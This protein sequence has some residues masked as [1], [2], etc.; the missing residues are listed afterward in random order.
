MILEAKNVL[1]YVNYTQA[2][3]TAAK[4]RFLF[5]VTLTFDL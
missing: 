3:K 4:C 5:L 1:P 2:T